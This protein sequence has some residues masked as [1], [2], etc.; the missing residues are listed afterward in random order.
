MSRTRGGGWSLAVIAV[1]SA[2][3][4]AACGDDDATSP[5]S[6]RL[7]TAATA[8]AT[9]PDPAA[10]THGPAAPTTIAAGPTA[11]LL[12][13]PTG[14]LDTGTVI[15]HLRDE[16]RPD[17]LGTSGAP[18]ELMAQLW[19][20]AEATDEPRAPY[21]PPGEAAALQAFYPV[22]AGAFTATT[23]SALGAPAVEGD[24]PVVF[25]YHGLC[26]SRTDSTIVAEQLASDG[27]VVVALASTGESL[28]VQFPDGTVVSTTDP[29]SC[30]VGADPYSPEGKAVVERLLGV[31]VDDVAFTL[32]ELERL[33]DGE[34][35]DADGAELPDGL[36]DTMDLSTLGIYGHSF[37]GSTA[38]AVMAADDRFAAGVDLDGLLAGPVATAGLDRPFLLVGSSYH[39]ATFDPSWATFIPALTG[40]HRWITVQHAGHYRF[41][42]L[43]GSVRHWGLDTSLKP[44]D[45]VTWEQIFGDVD[46]AASVAINRDLVGGF[47]DQFLNDE[48]AAI[49]D[50]P[51]AAHPELVDQPGVEV[52]LS[53]TPPTTPG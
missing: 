6:T 41:I 26:A 16:A 50:D 49:F 4:L 46:D 30:T 8:A 2:L 43:G 31:R 35:P 24:H 27:Y 9:T 21:A 51:A 5:G 1:S 39:D 11:M 17:P 33:A 28:G 48:P 29:A 32:A 15:L 42:D 37:G 13:A 36:A 3:V 22:P 38:A 7:T 19:Y 40:W 23:N 34:N 53:P 52:T 44:A 47:F 18:R 25:F 45:P 12:P 14:D 20:P 10:P